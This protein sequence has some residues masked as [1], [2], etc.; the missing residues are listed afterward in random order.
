V[1]KHIRGNFQKEEF[2]RHFLKEAWDF[3]ALGEAFWHPFLGGNIQRR[4]FLGGTCYGRIS[5][6]EHIVEQF[7]QENPI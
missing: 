7:L 3:L 5:L 1:G 6:R 4:N 2:Q